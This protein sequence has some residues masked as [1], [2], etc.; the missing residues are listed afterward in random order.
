[1]I[2][3]DADKR[4]QGGL[5]CLVLLGLFIGALVFVYNT[6]WGEQE[7]DIKTDDCRATIWVDKDSPRTWF[8]KF[9]CTY[10]R[11]SASKIIAGTCAAVETD[12]LA[13]QT[14]YK[15]ARGAE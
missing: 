14:A 15:Y 11:N 12:G 4:N 5:G 6:F 9:T 10:T 7:G 13:C 3:G 1:M 2:A 8:K